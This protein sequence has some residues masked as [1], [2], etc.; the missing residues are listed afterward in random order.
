MNGIVNNINNPFIVMVTLY[1]FYKVKGNFLSSSRNLNQIVSSLY[2][3]LNKKLS[4]KFD[5]SRFRMKMKVFHKSLDFAFGYATIDSLREML[6]LNIT[7]ESFVIPGN[8]LIHQ[9]FDDVISQGI[10]K[11]VEKSMRELALLGQKLIY[12]CENID[13]DDPNDLR[14]H[15]LFKGVNNYINNYKDR[16]S[17]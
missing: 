6:A 15:P 16:V 3:G 5:N 10:G 2:K 13:I 4:I 17:K 14:F 9:T 7:N 12:N 1:D 11:S 8:D